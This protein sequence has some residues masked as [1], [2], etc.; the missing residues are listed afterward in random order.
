M[1]LVG[2]GYQG[3]VRGVQGNVERC[4]SSADGVMGRVIG[5][6]VPAKGVV[7]PGIGS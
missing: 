4:G 3:E 6:N 2:M 1:I 7:L 5:S